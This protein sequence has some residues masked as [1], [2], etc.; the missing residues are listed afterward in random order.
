MNFKYI[1]FKFNKMPIKFNIESLTV[2]LILAFGN[3][4]SQ[5]SYNQG[6]MSCVIKIQ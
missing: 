4:K 6:F 5:S 1:F 2:E 3:N